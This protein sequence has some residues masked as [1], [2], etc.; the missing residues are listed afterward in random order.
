M[1]DSADDLKHMTRALELARQ[2]E[3]HVEPNPMVGCIIVRQGHTVGEGTHHRYGEP[4][5]EVIALERAGSQA[6]GATIYVS[7]EPC[8]HQGKTPP[9][10]RRL[11]Q[12][13]IG[14]AVV[15]L[16][17]PFPEVNGRGLKQLAAAGLRVDA[18]LLEMEA[19]RVL[20]PYLKL[21]TTGR[22][23]VIAKWAMSLDGKIAT[24][25]GE[26]QWISGPES[27]AVVHQLRGRVD[28]VLVG[29]GTAKTDDPLL[30]ARPTG[31]RLATRVVVDSSAALSTKSRLVQTVRQA[32]VLVA[33]SESARPD[34]C[35]A[36]QRAGV[37]VLQ[38]AGNTYQKR[39]DQLLL[40][41]GH[42]GMTNVLV[43]G[44][45][46]LLGELF[47]AKQVD[48]VHV[49]VAGKIL[50]GQAAPTPVGGQG[51]TQLARAWQLKNL[52]TRPV[53]QDIYL[54]ARV[55]R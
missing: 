18:G 29:R 35:E 10:T 27:R 48:E 54:S 5:A 42:R 20:A 51:I 28:A 38:I 16:S 23:W 52:V 8:C 31:P 15:A 46:T 21:I 24:V 43:E 49:F 17:D 30:T 39:F 26:S 6:R 1:S 25:G 19:K 32:P 7:L 47:S 55:A 40:Q 33:V 36:L 37:E 3:G 12:A 9:C 22:P 4:H 41:L 53:G 44:G 14:R 50:G 11:I 2:G 34:R 45:E 13:G